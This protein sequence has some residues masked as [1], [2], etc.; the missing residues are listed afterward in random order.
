[1]IVVAGTFIF[2]MDLCGEVFL[3]EYMNEIFTYIYIC[4]GRRWNE[5]AG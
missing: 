3:S 5:V 1:M 2:I 4:I